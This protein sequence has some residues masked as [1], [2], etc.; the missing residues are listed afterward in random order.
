M[1]IKPVFA[2]SYEMWTMKTQIEE[3]LSFKSKIL[4]KIFGLN[5]GPDGSWRIKTNEELHKLIKRRNIVRDT[6]S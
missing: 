2:Y 6:K 1:I 4:Q 5:K 3:K